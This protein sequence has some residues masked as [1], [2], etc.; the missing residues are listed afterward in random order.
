[1]NPSAESCWWRRPDLCYEN[2][3]LVFAGVAVDELAGRS[4]APAF[5][6]SAARVVENLGRVRAALDGAGLGGRSRIFY[7][8][9]ANRYAPLLSSLAAT[10]SCGID[11]CSPAEV[12]HALS[13]GFTEAD[14]SFT[15]TSL[16]ATDFDSLARWPG[17][18]VNFDSL[19][20]LRTWGR[21]RPGSAVGIR[22]NPAIGVGRGSNEKLRYSGDTVTKFGIYREQFAEALQLCREARLDLTTIHF[23]T[24][25]G[26]LTPQLPQWDAV[27][28]TCLQFLDLAPS[29]RRVNVGGG[30][31]VPHVAGDLPLDLS[32]WGN[33]LAHRFADRGLAVDVEPG[34]YLV[35]DAGLLVLEITYDELKRDRRFVGVNGGFNIAPEPAHYGLPFQPL[36]LGDALGPTSPATVA[37]N[38]NEALDVWYQD[39]LLP[40]LSGERHLA[41]INA[42]AYSASMASHHCLRGSFT[43]TLLA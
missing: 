25:C 6:Y 7:A 40:D 10:R 43:E 38:I 24:G 39:A 14:I 8:M 21:L 31:G 11:A 15:G 29:V 41:L 30:L 12:A 36:P 37:G 16:S 18:H 42:G 3:R 27:L 34:D 32:A 1:M 26:Y 9:K 17:L 19:H 4:T 35:K 2:G 20:A 13:C 23:H 5:F 22:V 28:E 33:I